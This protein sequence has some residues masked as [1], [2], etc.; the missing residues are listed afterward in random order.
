MAEP[1]QPAAVPAKPSRAREFKEVLAELT[2]IDSVRGGLIVTPDG[3][4]ITS[5]LPARF[6]VEAVGALAATLGRELELGPERSEKG[7]FRTALFSSDDGTVFLGDSP[8]GFLVLLGDRNVNL[9]AVRL[10]MRKAVD[11][12]QATWK[13]TA[14][15]AA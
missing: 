2:R 4:V 15:G 8:V 14:P 3:L 1:V 13:A 11:R 9:A 12:I 5:E 10:A 6:P 7:G